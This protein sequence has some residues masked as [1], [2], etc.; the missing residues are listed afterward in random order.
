MLNLPCL[1]KVVGQ[2][3]YKLK[4]NSL[5]YKKNIYIT[6]CSYIARHSKPQFIPPHPKLTPP[7]TPNPWAS[8][9][10]SDPRTPPGLDRDEDAPFI[11]SLT[12]VPPED[13]WVAMPGT[14]SSLSSPA[15]GISQPAPPPSSATRGTKV[16][17]QREE[18][19]FD[20]E[21]MGFPEKQPDAEE[22]FL[23][24]LAPRLRSLSE[25]RRSS[26]EIEIMPALHRA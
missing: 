1:L 7:L 22:L 20:K 24:S 16:K 9:S 14:A 21:V 15:T 12:A 23:L 26:G 2:K 10:S 4:L 5:K 3:V 17:R 19:G 11:L 6:L 13:Y 25:E 18:D 8:T